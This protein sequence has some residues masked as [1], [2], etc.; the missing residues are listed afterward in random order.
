MKYVRYI[1]QILDFHN[2]ICKVYIYHILD[3]KIIFKLIIKNDLCL[4][5]NV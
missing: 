1:Y 3:F 5:L 4:H 2:E